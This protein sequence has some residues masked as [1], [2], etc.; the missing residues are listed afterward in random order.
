VVAVN[1]ARQLAGEEIADDA[2]EWSEVFTK[3]AAAVAEEGD[4]GQALF[5]LAGSGSAA[6]GDHKGRVGNPLS[7]IA[8][9]ASEIAGGV[10]GGDH[11]LAGELRGE[12]IGEMIEED[13]GSVFGAVVVDVCTEGVITTGGRKEDR[14]VGGTD[15]GKDVLENGP[16]QI[17]EVEFLANN[18]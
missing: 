15:L 2:H 8:K 17:F 3:G 6:G 13:F 10:V 5:G 4:D 18:R 12:G 1:D 7:V 11:A 14:G 16:Q 9:F